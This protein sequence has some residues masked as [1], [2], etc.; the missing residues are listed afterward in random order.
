VILLFVRGDGSTL[1]EFI[2]ESSMVVIDLGLPDACRSA[3]VCEG[4]AIV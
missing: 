2:D 3:L 4:L 1:Y